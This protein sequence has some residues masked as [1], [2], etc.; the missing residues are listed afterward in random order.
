[1]P[2]LPFSKMHG[3]GNDFIVLAEESVYS[4][5]LADLA[6]RL[7]VRRFGIGADGLVLVGKGARHPVRMRMFNPDGSEDMCGNGLRCVARW[8]VRQ[9]LVESSQFTVETLDGDKGV[10]LLPDG[11]VR[12]EL[13]EPHFEP[14]QVPVVAERSPV[15]DLPVK[16]PLSEV[17]LTAL[18]TGSTHAVIFVPEL[19]QD[20]RFL[21]DSPAL[22]N[23]PLFPQRTSVMWTVVESTS[24]LRMRI[25]ERGAG[26]TLACGTGA[27]AAA[28][29]AQLHGFVGEEVEVSSKG[30]VLR[31]Q[32]RPGLPIYLTGG[33]EFVFEGFYPVEEVKG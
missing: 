1:M 25:W 6:R 9:G 4:L 7:C 10:E 3:A 32:W 19:P 29:A 13:G 18:S 20:E 15:I 21:R 8:A 17:R 2:L 22:E 31:V 5:A 26:E 24:R 12:V 16:L 14:E 28:I 11:T 30:G 27:C 33:A 23:H